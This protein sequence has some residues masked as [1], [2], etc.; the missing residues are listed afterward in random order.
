[1]TAHAAAEPHLLLVATALFVIN[2]STGLNLINGNHK[3]FQ[4][5]TASDIARAMFKKLKQKIEAGDEGGIERLSFSPSRTPG[6]IV[7]SP[8]ASETHLSFS[9]PAPSPTKPASPAQDP[10][11]T[12]VEDEV[13]RRSRSPAE[14]VT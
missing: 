6:S 13:S 3:K 2:G 7:R 12:A 5:A 4:P 11:F 8:P 10:S 1:M 14:E 9:P